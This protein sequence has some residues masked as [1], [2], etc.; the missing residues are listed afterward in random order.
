MWPDWQARLAR[1]GPSTFPRYEKAGSARG[2]DRG[3]IGAIHFPRQGDKRGGRE[4]G[5]GRGARIRIRAVFRCMATT[6]QSYISLTLAAQRRYV[7]G[8][9]R[10]PRTQTLQ[11]ERSHRLFSPGSRPTA[12]SQT[13]SATPTGVRA[14]WACRLMVLRT[15]KCRTTL[16]M[17]GFPVRCGPLG[18]FNEK[19]G[20]KPGSACRWPQVIHTK[21]IRSRLMTLF[22]R[23]FN[24]LTP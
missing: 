21:A 22:N 9:R 2:S 18:R 15:T 4:G 17:G 12:S 6:L 3:Q 19:N 23:V 7:L 14:R 1:L 10:T 13:L 16:V 24:N 20:R 11:C 8:H 5:Q